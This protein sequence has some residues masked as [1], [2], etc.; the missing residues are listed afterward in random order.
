VFQLIEL[1][2]HE[3]M[4]RFH[5][6]VVGGAVG[7][8]EAV[9]AAAVFLLDQA[10]ERRGG[11]AAV[12]GAAELAAVVGLYGEF[13][14]LDPA[15]LQVGQQ[16]IAKQQ[17]VGGVVEGGEG[18]PDAALG[19]DAGG[20]LEA[21]QP[22]GDQFAVARQIREVF[23]VHLKQAKGRP[24]EFLGGQ[25]AGRRARLFAAP[26]APRLL[27]DARDGAGRAG[28][29]KIALEAPGAK[30]GDGI[31]GLEHLLLDFGRGFVGDVVRGAGAL[32]QPG[33]ALLLVAAQPQAHGVARASEG[34]HGGAD[35]LAQGA[36]HDLVADGELGILAAHHFLVG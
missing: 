31:A 16:A 20:E 2:L 9:Q 15:S 23:D 6:A 7:R 8:V 13:L 34:A 3:S 14:Q 10:G 27:E 4:H 26:A 21:G 11:A 25:A 17:G 29:V 32:L 35:T 12:P 19:H 5:V 24:S 30:A 18:Q 36:E 1:L 22:E 28:Q 33:Q